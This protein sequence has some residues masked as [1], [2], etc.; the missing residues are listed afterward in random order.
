MNHDPLRLL[1][2]T[3]FSHETNATVFHWW[4]GLLARRA[5][6]ETKTETKMVKSGPSEVG[7][8]TDFLG[9]S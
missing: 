1:I 5:E 3:S 6:A 8:A 9:T 7:S 4:G 2:T